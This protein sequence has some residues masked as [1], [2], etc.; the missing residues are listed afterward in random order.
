MTAVQ[1]ELPPKLLPVFQGPA[2][3]RGAYGGRGSAKTRSFAKMSAIA[4]YRLGRAGVSGIILCAREHLVTLEE[5]SMEEVKQVIAEVPWLAAYYDVGEKYIRSR[6]GRVRYAFSGLRHNVAAIKSKARI[7]IAWVDE[8]EEVS[9]TAWQFLIPTLRDEGPGWQSELWVTWNPGNE[10]SATHKRFRQNPP[11]DSKIVSL[12]WMDNPWFP[13]TL[14]AVRL[15]DLKDRPDT[16]GHVWD[17]DFLIISDAL[18]FKDKF[19]MGRFE[20]EPSWNGPYHGLDFGFAEDPTA[21]SQV[22]INDDILYVRREL[23]RKKLELDDTAQALAAEIPQAP[24][25]VI[26]ADSARPESISYLSRSGLPRIIAAR[27]GPGSVEDGVA[28][29]KSFRRIIIHEDCPNIYH[30]FMLYSYKVDRLTND[31][32]PVFLDKDNH[33]IDSI[34]YAVEPLIRARAK[35]RLRA[36]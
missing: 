19:E 13:S 34:R 2:R 31:I 22:Y 6:D 29:L 8:A 14:N 1:I 28:F 4:G 32:L 17:G 18:V 15:N 5:S 7:L 33:G 27:K 24:F 11:S 9:E 12:N 36:I 35:P 16:Y 23:Y 21:G 3:V 10:G 26:R 20:P 30:E 25:H